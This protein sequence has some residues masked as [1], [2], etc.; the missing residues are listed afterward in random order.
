MAD[1]SQSLSLDRSAEDVWEVVGDPARVGEWLPMVSGT[2]MEGDLRFASISGREGTMC[3]RIV[4]HSDEERSYSYE[5]VDS[6]MRMRSYLST[7][8][9]L[10]DGEG[11]LVLWEVD[12]EPPEGKDKARFAAGIEATYRSGLR[13]LKEFFER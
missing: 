13:S 1:V 9:V 5:V 7:L 3:E 4:S 11:S 2:R 6:P 8:S 10:A 12:F